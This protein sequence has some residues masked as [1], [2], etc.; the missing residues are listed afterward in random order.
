MPWISS[1]SR[2]DGLISCYEQLREQTLGKGNA[3]GSGHGLAL[4]MRSGMRAWM[5]A[6]QHCIECVPARRQ[7]G[8]DGELLI[9]LEMRTEV[10]M[11]VVGIVLHDYQEARS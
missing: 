1:P 3:I 8:R 4:L 10:A 11:I 2:N 9:P 7:D 5:Q 6:W